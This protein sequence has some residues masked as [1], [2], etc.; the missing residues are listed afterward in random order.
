[1]NLD[2]QKSQSMQKFCKAIFDLYKERLK[3]EESQKDV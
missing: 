1:M 2:F 3:W